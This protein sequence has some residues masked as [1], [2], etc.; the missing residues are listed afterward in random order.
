MSATQVISGGNPL[1]AMH[2]LATSDV[3]FTNAKCHKDNI[4]GTGLSR[5]RCSFFQRLAFQLSLG[6]TVP[7]QHKR[8]LQK[9]VDKRAIALKARL[10]SG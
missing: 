7:V 8:I 4:Q 9:D 1:V 5:A 6:I 10:T 3:I 2:C